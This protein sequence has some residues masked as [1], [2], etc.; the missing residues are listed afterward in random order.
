M[1]Y[2]SSL[3]S[4]GWSMDEYFKYLSMHKSKFST[5]VF[6]FAANSQNYDLVSHQSLHDAW[7]EFFS[8]VELAS[9]ERSQVRVI[10]IDCRFLGPYHDVQI[11]ITYVDV[12]NYS[13]S[14]RSAD[15]LNSTASVGHGD[16]LMHEVN[17]TERGSITHEMVFSL[18]GTFKIE[19]RD[20]IHSVRSREG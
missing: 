16:L 7:L 4:G 18:G 14:G 8:I 3:P 2:I 11:Y 10:N 9:G 15:H 13:L 20:I 17:V 1:N 5:A 19:C 6:D 12:L